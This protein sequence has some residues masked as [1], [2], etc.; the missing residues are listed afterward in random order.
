MDK[1]MIGG[2]LAMLWFGV[3]LFVFYVTLL[4]EN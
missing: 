3:I 4:K 2:I 1:E